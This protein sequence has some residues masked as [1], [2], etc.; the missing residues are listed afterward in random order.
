MTPEQKIKREI[1]LDLMKSEE[2]GFDET[3]IT[4][5]TVDGFYRDADPCDIE[6]EF[7][8]GHVETDITPEYSSHYESRSVAT[9]TSDGEWIGWTYWYGGGKYGEPGSIDWMGEAYELDCVEEQK[10]VTVRK[11]TRKS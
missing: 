4:A 5:D 8:E 3:E 11:F 2:L 10:V 9:K 7:R 6:Y 1:L